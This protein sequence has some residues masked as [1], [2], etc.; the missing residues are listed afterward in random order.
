MKI[1]LIQI[2]KTDESFISTGVTIYKERLQHYQRIEELTLKGPAIAAKQ[3]VEIQKDAEGKGILKSVS[4]SD[5]LIL[6]DEK[7]KQLTSVELANFF[8]KFSFST[9]KTVVFCIGGA[10]GFSDAVYARA[11][12]KLSFS[13]FTLSHQMIRLF[14]WE[15]IYRAHT[16]IKREKYHHH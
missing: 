5:Y 7:G 9:T 16:I 11:D 3:G 15:Q 6:L 8:E 10:F 14:F 1:K 4:D 12:E 13:K 2:G